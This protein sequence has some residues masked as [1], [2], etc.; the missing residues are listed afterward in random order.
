MAFT[1]Q[2]TGSKNVSGI[3]CPCKAKM[4][5]SRRDPGGIASGI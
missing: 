4:A 3:A 1:T 5:A 2:L